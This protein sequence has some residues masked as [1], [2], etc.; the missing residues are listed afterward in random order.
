MTTQSIN[1]RQRLVDHLHGIA[2]YKDKGYQWS[3]HTL[4]EMQVN[5]DEAQAV[6]LRL[7]GEIGKAAFS[8]GLLAELQSGAGS[9]DGSGNLAE[10]ARRELLP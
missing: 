9:R 5:Q 3:R 8:R 2:G 1:A 7:I 6:I 4:A 10:R